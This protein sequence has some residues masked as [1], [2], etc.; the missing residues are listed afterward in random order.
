MR[1]DNIGAARH[2]HREPVIRTRDGKVR[3]SGLER[4]R[5]EK[6]EAADRRGDSSVNNSA[7]ARL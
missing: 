2:L 6:A 3:V 7:D 1:C 4:I 5:S